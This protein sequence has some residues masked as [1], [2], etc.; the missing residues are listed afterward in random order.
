MH[1]FI[2]PICEK[3]YAS[4]AYLDYHLK[5]CQ[6]GK[7]DFNCNQ[8]DYK[9]NNKRYFSTHHQVH[10][11]VKHECPVCQHKL[12]TEADLKR[13]QRSMHSNIPPTKNYACDLCDSSFTNLTALKNH[14]KTHTNNEGI[15]VKCRHC[16]YKTWRKAEMKKHEL[17]HF[18]EKRDL[19]FKCESCDYKT[20]TRKRLT[21]H[22]N[23]HSTLRLVK[24]NDCPKTFKYKDQ[25][26]SHQ[27]FAH[28]GAAK[29]FK[30][31][32]IG[33]KKLFSTNFQ[34]LR[35]TETHA[36]LEKIHTCP[37]CAMGFP[38]KTG[39]KSHIKVH[40]SPTK[41]F[42]C[43]QCD[44]RFRNDPHLRRHMKLHQIETSQK[45]FECKVC[46]SSFREKYNLTRHEKSV[47]GNEFTTFE[48]T[49]C[50]KTFQKRAALKYHI[51]IHHS[52]QNQQVSC[53]ICEKTYS[54]PEI[55][56]R[57]KKFVHVEP[58]HECFQCKSKFKLK[59]KLDRHLKAV[60]K[61]KHK[62]VKIKQQ[63]PD[64]IEMSSLVVAK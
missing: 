51:E 8:C 60:H 31:L 62:K 44:K 14:T 20:W 46:G 28:L 5:S 16:E 2:C 19:K 25:L 4:T 11:S 36:N 40:R 58:S 27:K 41:W 57:H 54:H 43:N 3:E 22:L 30:C 50:P 63:I 1:K 12:S 47:H 55:L 52:K 38:L 17:T 61:E 39:L 9:T 32:E 24:C 64:E 13:H 48:C 56:R 18:P 23:V 33:C 29:D 21:R 10:S 59:S 34:L 37:V 49:D 45:E 15:E 7:Y 53:S 6:D 42:D 26:R 35:H